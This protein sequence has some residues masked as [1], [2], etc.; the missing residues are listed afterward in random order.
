MPSSGILPLSPSP[1]PA[2]WSPYVG[3]GLV[4]GRD[5]YN[6]IEWKVIVLLASL[7]PLAEAFERT[8]GANLV[9]SQIVVLTSG[10]PVWVALAVLMAV[11]MTM[12]DFLTTWRRH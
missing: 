3:L 8:G 12:S 7:I 10:Y 11:T 4:S 9:A 1:W 5:V 2:P 6:S